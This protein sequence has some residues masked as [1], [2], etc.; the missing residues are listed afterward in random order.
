MFSRRYSR[1]QRILWSERAQAQHAQLPLAK[2]LLKISQ[3]NL[4]LG[5]LMGRLH[6]M[7]VQWEFQ[8]SK[9]E[10]LYH[11]EVSIN[12]GIPKNG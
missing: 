9:M 10:V 4:S 6:M 2:V 11:M 1:S 8:D 3:L 12:G 5:P 7:P